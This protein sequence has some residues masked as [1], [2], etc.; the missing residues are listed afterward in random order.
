MFHNQVNKDTVSEELGI[1]EIYKGSAVRH[2]TREDTV[3]SSLTE[4]TAKSP[5]A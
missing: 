4:P 5:H 2:F 3:E 1:C